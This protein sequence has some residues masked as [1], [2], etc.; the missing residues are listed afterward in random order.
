MTDMT[1]PTDRTDMT[2]DEHNEKMRELNSD[3]NFQF[4]RSVA[5]ATHNAFFIVTIEAI[6]NL[7][8]LGKIGVRNAGFDD[9]FDRLQAV[10]GEHLSIYEAIRQ[11]DAARARAEMQA[12]IAN[13]RQH[14]FERQDLA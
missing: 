14:I 4:H 1:E 6:P 7:I 10:L 8:G 13:A 12:H 9:P 2:D 5:R 11:R 3:L